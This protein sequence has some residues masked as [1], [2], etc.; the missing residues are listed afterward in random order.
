MIHSALFSNPQNARYR[1]EQFDLETGEEGHSTLDRPV[2]AQFCSN[3]KNTFLNAATILAESGKVDAVD[4][5]LVS[6][7]RILRAVINRTSDS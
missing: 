6:R 4:L 7:H 3:D 2:I 5:N 1:K